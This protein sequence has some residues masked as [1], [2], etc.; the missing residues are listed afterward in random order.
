MSEWEWEEITKQNH[1]KVHN[2][3]K[4]KKKKKKEKNKYIV[5]IMCL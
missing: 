1:T 2:K 5:N 4:K 3:Q